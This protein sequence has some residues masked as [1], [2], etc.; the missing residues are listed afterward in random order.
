VLRNVE[1]FQLMSRDT[2]S[3]TNAPHKHQQ[4]ERYPPDHSRVPVNPPNAV[5][6]E[7]VESS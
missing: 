1:A 4:H 3:G 2:R 7:D 5:G 6:P